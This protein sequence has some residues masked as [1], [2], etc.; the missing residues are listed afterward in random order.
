MPNFSLPDK[1]IV[2]TGASRGLGKAMAIAVGEAGGHVTAV[3]RGHTQLEDTCAAVAAAGGT[4]TAT[5]FD[6]NASATD[7]D[8]WIG[9]VH[10]A[11]PIDGVIHAA[12][13]QLRH[14]ATGFPIEDFRH[15][16]RVNL[17]TPFLLSQAVAR[18]QSAAG[19]PGSHVMIGS[20]GS[21]I[22]LPRGAAYTASKTGLLG[23]ART[24]SI[25]WAARGIRVNVIGP[26]Y[27]F[28]ELT[29]DLLTDPAQ[30]ARV[31]SRI[32][33]GRLGDPVELGGAA[34]FL[35]SEASSYITGQLI[36]VDGG[37]LA[38]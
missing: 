20:L 34:V 6:L 36:N 5:P 25:E 27:F 21:S 32:P 26:G 38:S 4:A 3:A 8:A 2:V 14:E 11:R 22:G 24:L 13:V 23:L 29:R 16:L 1:H 12:G 33:A 30:R 31:L 10:D 9:A 7:L 15:I 28:T 35:L 19:M 17:E 18:R 37:W